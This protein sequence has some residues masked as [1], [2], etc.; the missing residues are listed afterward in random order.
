MPGS[1]LTITQDSAGSPI[2]SH[3]VGHS[4]GLC[5]F[6]ASGLA[7]SGADFR[8][9]L[10]HSFP[11]SQIALFPRSQLRAITSSSPFTLFGM[12]GTVVGH[13]R[14]VNI[15]WGDTRVR[16]TVN[17]KV[18]RPGESVAPIVVDLQW[19]KQSTSD[20]W[21]T[22]AFLMV[23]AVLP[24]LMP[25]DTRGELTFTYGCILTGWTLAFTL[26]AI[27]TV[28]RRVP[29]LARFGNRHR[30]AVFVAL[31]AAAVLTFGPIALSVFVPGARPLGMIF[32]LGFA[33]NFAAIPLWL[34]ERRN[35]RR[36]A[37]EMR[38][39]V[40][41]GAGMSAPATVAS[42]AQADPG[43]LVL[44]VYETE[45]LPPSP[46]LRRITAAAN[47]VGEAPCRILHLYNFFADAMSTQTRPISGWR[48]H[49]PVAMLASPLEL[50]RAAG[51]RL[52]AA[53]SVESLLLGD[54]AKIAA[55][56]A[57]ISDAPTP[58]HPLSAMRQRL[59]RWQKR[60]GRNPR[61]LLPTAYADLGAY[62][63]DVL[64]CT[65]RTWQQG[66]SALTERAA[67]V[68]MDASDFSPAR[69]GLIWEIQHV[70]DHFSTQDFVV[71]VNSFT[72]LPALAE[73]FRKAW[74]NMAA[75]SPNHRAAESR[76]R[77]VL[78]IGDDRGGLDSEDVLGARPE[79]IRDFE[80][81]A[82]HHRIMV[83]LREAATPGLSDSPSM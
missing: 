70:I 16:E 7:S 18:Y 17:V 26:A 14:C 58:A 12:R 5:Q 28:S 68:V 4:L 37:D 11:N 53:H 15:R 80:R 42:A 38:E 43:E 75:A 66:I 10:G 63:E 49:G 40:Q 62:S 50:A 73:A 23:G 9:F 20:T 55:R 8:V 1:A 21:F 30:I 54:S 2:E 48:L 19:I 24:W 52:D 72:D 27:S 29:A 13:R 33:V 44:E 67:K 65:D 82:A 71:I 61:L 64:L 59:V 76:L 25:K 3:S 56:V 81:I 47:V 77:I 31:V 78:L 60:L 32:L 74:R 46:P 51:Y 83:L 45:D 6:G 22:A 36:I 57:G 34:V 69:H 39:A 35:A 41:I 79:E